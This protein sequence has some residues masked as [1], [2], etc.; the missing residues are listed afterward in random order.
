ML[1]I[2][3]LSE[4]Y[5]KFED[6]VTEAEVAAIYYAGHGSRFTA[7][8]ISSRPTPSLRAVAMPMMKPLHSTVDPLMS[9]RNC[10]SLS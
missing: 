6:S 4:R 5:G 3:I 1:A 9:R 10:G 8:I 7:L 2:W